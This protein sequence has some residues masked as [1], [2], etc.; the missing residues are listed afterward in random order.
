MYP[1]LSRNASGRIHGI[2]KSVRQK[3]RHPETSL[4][5]RKVGQN[6]PSDVFGRAYIIRISRE[7]LD[8]DIVALL[9]GGM[10]IV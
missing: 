6:A 8:M 4:R 1:E 2:G 7:V 9:L 5:R 3:M 10:I